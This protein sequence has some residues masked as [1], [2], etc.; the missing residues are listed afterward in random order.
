VA[1]VSI[2]LDAERPE[3][4]AGREY[5]GDVVVGGAVN[6]RIDQ[7][8]RPSAEIVADVRAAIVAGGCGVPGGEAQRREAW[9]LIAAGAA[10]PLVARIGSP[11]VNAA[12][13]AAAELIPG[14]DAAVKEATAK[15][16]AVNG[17][18]VNDEAVKGAP[19][20]GP[21]GARPPVLLPRVWGLTHAN[22]HWRTARRPHPPA[23]PRG[24]A[25]SGNGGSVG[26]GAGFVSE[27]GFSTGGGYVGDGAVVE[28]SLIVDPNASVRED[29]KSSPP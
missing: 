12:A 28:A 25:D 18:K 19:V 9:P 1:E 26:T 15:G 2:S 7:L 8:M 27:S 22:V 21:G 13:A 5:S 24:D 23:H 6:P 20:N 10:A 14:L 17:A 29:G 16:A 3:V 11:L 4:E